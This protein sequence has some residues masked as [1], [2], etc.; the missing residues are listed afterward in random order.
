MRAA[1]LAVAAA[2]GACV[3]GEGPLM[4]PGQDCLGCHGGGE[5][6]RWTAAGTWSA[7]GQ[8]VTFT[9]ANGRTVTV[10]TNQA[11]NFYTAEPLA[12]PLAV[13]V[14]GAAMPA[15]VT[16]GGC[17]RC[18]DRGGTMATGPNMLPGVDCLSCHDGSSGVKR[19]TAAGTWTGGATVVL[20]GGTTVTLSGQ[21]TVG[22]FFTEAALVFPLTA[23]VNG[24][25]MPA[26]VTYGGCNRCHGAG[27]GGGD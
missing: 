26:P 12:L 1:L 18:H 24:S 16:Y 19:F 6:R 8:H 15:P 17:N 20:S 11:G 21:S 7:Q 27:G 3:P 13:S 25:A 5:A 4:S 22:N 10:R 23:R 9:D 14:D 2:L